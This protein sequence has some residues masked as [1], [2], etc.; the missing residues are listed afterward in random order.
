MAEGRE[1][2][3]SN[4]LRIISGMSNERR[5]Y[6]VDAAR[7]QM[8]NNPDRTIDRSHLQNKYIQRLQHYQVKPSG[9]YVLP[10]QELPAGIDENIF[11]AFKFE[12][13][14][15]KADIDKLK[16]LQQSDIAKEGLALPT[17]SLPFLKFDRNKDQ[18]VLDDMAQFG[19]DAPMQYNVFS[20]EYYDIHAKLKGFYYRIGSNADMQFAD[21]NTLIQKIE[22]GEISTFQAIN[23]VFN[24]ELTHKQS[25]VPFQIDT[26]LTDEYGAH[27]MIRDI[28]GKLGGA[29][30]ST[31]VKAKDLAEIQKTLYGIIEGQASP[32][33]LRRLS[34]LPVVQTEDKQGLR[35]FE[36]LKDMIGEAMNRSSVNVYY[37]DKDLGRYLDSIARNIIENPDKVVLLN[38]STDQ[39]T[40]SAN[41]ERLAKRVQQLQI[42]RF[43]Q[44]EPIN[45]I[46][47]QIRESK[48]FDISPEALEA[49]RDFL[50]RI[51]GTQVLS[52]LNQT[53]TTEL[54]SAFWNYLETNPQRLEQLINLAESGEIPNLRNILAGRFVSIEDTIKQ[55]LRNIET[56]ILGNFVGRQHDILYNRIKSVES[57]L[58]TIDTS[59]PVSEYINQLN[60]ITS[61]YNQIINFLTT[62]E[63]DN[64]PTKIDLNTL[65]VFKALQGRDLNQLFGDIRVEDARRILYNLLPSDVNILF[66]DFG[67]EGTDVIRQYIVKQ[68][69]Q[70]MGMTPEELPDVLVSTINEALPDEQLQTYINAVKNARITLQSKKMF[71]AG[72]GQTLT[73]EEVVKGIIALFE[74]NR[75]GQ[76]GITVANL[77]YG[78]GTAKESPLSF[79]AKHA[80]R[81]PTEALS[82]QNATFVSE[83]YRVVSA[84]ASGNERYKEQVKL[85]IEALTPRAFHQKMIGTLLTSQF[86]IHASQE[87]V[88]KS[89][90]AQLSGQPKPLSYY[91]L[92]FLNMMSGGEQLKH[93]TYQPLVEAADVA[94][95]HSGQKEYIERL[96]Q[97]K[98][99]PKARKK[100]LHSRFS[101]LMKV[102]KTVPG[103]S[104]YAKDYL[105][106]DL[107]QILSPIEA[108]R[109]G[110]F[111]K[112]ITPGSA[113]MLG[114]LSGYQNTTLYKMFSELATWS[115]IK[116]YTDYENAQSVYE[117][118]AKIL[119][120]IETSLQTK[121]T[122][123]IKQENIDELAKYLTKVPE[124][125]RQLYATQLAYGLKFSEHYKKRS[126][127]LSRVRAEFVNTINQ[128]KETAGSS[129]DF[130]FDFDFFYSIPSIL[131]GDAFNQRMADEIAKRMSSDTGQA[132]ARSFAVSLSNAINAPFHTLPKELQD[133]YLQQGR[134]FAETFTYFRIYEKQ[135]PSV[136]LRMLPELAK[137]Y[138]ALHRTFSV[139][140]DEKNAYKIVDHI[141][142]KDFWRNINIV[143]N[144]LNTQNELFER[145]KGAG[146]PRRV[147]LAKALNK[148]NLFNF[149]VYSVSDDELKQALNQLVDIQ[150]NIISQLSGGS[151]GNIDTVLNK[152]L[153]NANGE[154]I[155][156][157]LGGLVTDEIKQIYSQMYGSVPKAIEETTDLRAILNNVDLPVKQIVLSSL[158]EMLGVKHLPDF[159]NPESVEAFLSRVT[160][161]Q[162]GKLNL[163]NVNRYTVKGN[164]SKTINRIALSEAEEN[165]LNQ[166]YL[167]FVNKLNTALA[168]K[169]TSFLTFNIISKNI[170]RKTFVTIPAGGISLGYVKVKQGKKTYSRLAA[171]SLVPYEPA[172]QIYKMMQFDSTFKKTIVDKIAEVSKQFVF[173]NNT[174]GL[175][176]PLQ[177][178]LKAANALAKGNIDEFIDFVIKNPGNFQTFL[179][180]AR[181][182]VFFADSSAV[183]NRLAA[184][185]IFEGVND[186]VGQMQN[187]T[188]KLRKTLQDYLTKTLNTDAYTFIGTMTGLYSTRFKQTDTMQI[189]LQSFFSDST[190]PELFFAPLYN[191]LQITGPE[192]KN[193]DQ[194]I[195]GFLNKPADVAYRALYLTSQ[196]S[197]KDKQMLFGQLADVLSNRKA[198]EFGNTITQF[199]QLVKEQQM[200]GM[201]T[202]IKQGM[203]VGGRQAIANINATKNILNQIMTSVVNEQNLER[204]DQ[205]FNF[206]KLSE[207]EDIFN[208]ATDDLQKVTFLSN[209]ISA[210]A[211]L[212]GQK[213]KLETL[214]DAVAKMAHA[215]DSDLDTIQSQLESISDEQFN[216]FRHLV[217]FTYEVVGEQGKGQIDQ[218]LKTMMTST[219]G[220]AV[221]LQ[222]LELIN[223]MY[224]GA[225]QFK[226]GSEFDA[227]AQKAKQYMLQQQNADQL[228]E[229]LEQAFKSGKIKTLDDLVNVVDELIAEPQ[230]IPTGYEPIAR[231]IEAAQERGEEIKGVVNKIVIVK[232]QDGR[233]R[234]ELSAEKGKPVILDQHNAEAIEAVLF[235]SKEPVI[236][237]EETLDG[238]IGQIEHGDEHLV[239]RHREFVA[240]RKAQAQELSGTQGTK[241]IGDAINTANQ[242]KEGIASQVDQQ[243]NVLKDSKQQAEETISVTE[244]W[245]QMLKNAKEDFFDL[246][247]S[248]PRT[249]KWITGSILALGVIGAS[250]RQQHRDDIED[251][252]RVIQYNEYK[253]LPPVVNTSP[254]SV[255]MADMYRQHLY[256]SFT[257][258]N[259]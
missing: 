232:G 200:R 209:L 257:S 62:K 177:N 47:E 8:F 82:S 155:D 163:S 124:E 27:Q 16:Q 55:S 220:F 99:V 103:Q 14:L 70:M 2:R 20:G 13:G 74:T 125:Q 213:E 153:F 190:R 148:T 31:L 83:F 241:I 231:A 140:F 156:Q 32:D 255:V 78:F 67:T 256:N 176:E 56:N 170:L 194:Y 63:I 243:P 65:P 230:D 86:A 166:W 100:F 91:E 145:D 160:T 72:R 1:F 119:E 22:K 75:S 138:A 129:A 46:K 18:F 237:D 234:Y 28:L 79:I 152:L 178:A 122:I 135:T 204:L 68:F 218:I 207:L 9:S 111:S 98:D 258:R 34:W 184:L 105:L 235:S 259:I 225:V 219:E 113:I 23:P 5:M 110:T 52:N 41:L 116:Q 59:I 159:N 87:Q 88:R 250:V 180:A 58:N 36:T 248:H 183:E 221:G 128:M 96:A 104:T 33:Q 169:D 191:V 37:M 161:G 246:V 7:T 173:A 89:H 189:V 127:V 106:E 197:N 112:L 233:I 164:K 44:A 61:N 48:V 90:E 254:T 236:Q 210:E 93:R 24:I 198:T 115:N 222:K 54:T 141:A 216:R 208:F 30:Q 167:N 205:I 186:I 228:P 45:V 192:S 84:V 73:P 53:K 158:M 149:D 182:T 179:N 171:K 214:S 92:R 11:D 51:E 202:A 185:Q 239:E 215:A 147:S 50:L 175:A 4:L 85:G 97:V 211:T 174:V 181:A 57:Q 126:E 242:V 172:G 35:M 102:Y 212:T 188:Y 94:L 49:A 12:Q 168:G 134:E 26:V 240:A 165:V 60:K 203:H 253:E 109:L 43:G 142:T 252:K 143:G 69:A 39:K 108:L 132:I 199:S 19:K 144:V 15:F 66:T 249:T 247:K 64:A 137:R 195:K 151:A 224:G 81:K 42:E 3:I 227:I 217:D 131:T 17:I 95:Q 162:L 80:E 154:L 40:I 150:Y 223:R 38:A 118:R 101:T 114:E 117:I 201:K 238:V 187:D 157:Q 206:S 71:D 229:M 25:G 77:L 226:F 245:I 107:R 130:Y 121:G 196:G 244:K 193:I 10:F 136:K 21:I 123:S 139:F 6:L 133:V 120:D 251:L 29:E 76:K 146:I